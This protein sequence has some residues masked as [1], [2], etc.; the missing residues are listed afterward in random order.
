MLMFT[1]F[2]LPQPSVL[3]LNLK[4]R[5]LEI[6]LFASI[7]TGDPT[8]REIKMIQ[9]MSAEL[10]KR[11]PRWD[12]IG[13]SSYNI[14]KF[15]DDI[16][17]GQKFLIISGHID[18]EL[19][20]FNYLDILSQ[21][22]GRSM[23]NPVMKRL[24]SYLA[25]HYSGR[26]YRGN[27]SRHIGIY[28]KDKRICRFCDRRMPD[29]TFKHKSHAISEALGNKGLICLEE[30]DDCNKRFNESLEQ[31]I[32]KMMTPNLLM[33]GVAGKK[34]IPQ[35]KGDGFSVRIDTG[36]RAT[37]GRD[38]L[39]YTLRDMPNSR[40]IKKV[41]AGIN[42][43]YKTY[44]RYVPENVYKCLCKFVLSLIDSSELKHFKDTIAWINEPLAKHRLPP[45]WHYSVKHE[46]KTWE[47]TTSMIVMSRKHS[48]KNLPYCW[49]IIIIAGEPYLFIIPFCSQDKFKFVNK[50]KQEF[51]I[52]GISKMMN[53][54]QFHPMTMNRIKPVQI[55][56]RQSIEIP[57]ECLEGQDYS[58]IEQNL[59]SVI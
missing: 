43:D 14:K 6:G 59:E 18:D 13:D 22:N 57:P 24:I 21:L 58:L 4:Q 51:F 36:S 23:E 28:E 16:P 40:D 5:N 2:R 50:R 46:G 8:M 3:H 33:H 7:I 45:I 25:E 41:L 31:D 49:A 48:E 38:T 10:K 37:L 39:V 56:I 1:I 12:A 42:K 47:R 55:V 34:G 53:G 19:E 20:C 52:D 44:L 54:M 32:I 9:T 29:V 27:D 35:L 30:C 26:I 17:I 11:L 15:F